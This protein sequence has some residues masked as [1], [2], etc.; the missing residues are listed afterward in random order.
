MCCLHDVLPSRRALLYYTLLK[1]ELV[2]QVSR[3]DALKAELAF[4]AQNSIK[5][6]DSTR[7]P[8]DRRRYHS[9]YRELPPRPC[10]LFLRQRRYS[11]PLHRIG[12]RK[13]S[14]LGKC[15]RFA[16]KLPRNPVIPI[17]QSQSKAEIPS[18]S[19]NDI[20]VFAVETSSIFELLTPTSP[21]SRSP[22][23]SLKAANELLGPYGLGP[24]LLVFG[25]HPKI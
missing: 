6:S 15:T 11:S 9:S 13:N 5:H 1:N 2:S 20:M 25:V 3:R 23:A 22:D 21:L 18:A 8:G 4:P 17:N 7:E 14:D 12:I 10:A 24:T 19:E 16:R